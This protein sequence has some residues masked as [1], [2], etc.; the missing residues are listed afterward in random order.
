MDCCWYGTISTFLKTDKASW[1]YQMK[2]AHLEM[3]MEKPSDL[4]VDAWL[5]C[6]DVLQC[7]LSKINPQ[8]K[9]YHIIFEYLLPR[10]GGRRPDVILILGNHIVVLEFKQKTNYNEA[11]LDQAI[12]YARDIQ[13]YHLESRKYTVRPFLVATK[14]K[15]SGREHGPIRGLCPDEIP[16]LLNVLPIQPRNTDIGKWLKS[17][18]VPLPS[19]VEAAIDI[20]DNKELPHVKRASSAGIPDALIYLNDITKMARK[21]GERHI[22]FV[23]GVP[24][25]GKTLLGLQ[26]VY[27]SN[28]EDIPAVFLSGNGPLVQVLS[29][30]LESSILIK[31]IRKFI[32]TYIHSQNSP[33]ESIIV[34][35]EAQRA[36]DEHYK[37]NKHKISEPE[38]MIKITDKYSNGV[39]LLALI[40]EG[41]EIYLGEEGGINKWVQAIIKSTSSYRIH[42]PTKLLSSFNSLHPETS[43]LLDLDQSLRSHTAEATTAWIN[44]ILLGNFSEAKSLSKQIQNDG[45]GIYITDDLK[46]AKMYCKQKYQDSPQ[47]T[48]GLLASSRAKNLQPHGIRNDFESTAKVDYGKWY[49]DSAMS[50]ALC[51]DMQSVVTEFGCQ[52]LELDL[53]IICWGDDLLW[54]NDHWQSNGHPKANDPHKLLLNSYRVLLSRGRDGIIIFIPHEKK[55]LATYRCI[56]DSGAR[57]L[58]MPSSGT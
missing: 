49:N 37:K 17:E 23:T 41:Q 38:I 8:Y 14:R 50:I 48:Y 35:D 1:L 34:F 44:A 19:L 58:V 15:A 42:C 9:D 52:G 4:Q 24:G 11:D 31:G 56:V 47:K 16:A 26:M 10:E 6:F 12:G 54:V 53:P 46:K 33:R 30:A 51:R 36:W 57:K 20:F 40:G 29:N 39:V 45:F 27:Q 13:S 28:K 2:A 22:I 3:L 55:M 43:E 18:Y 21:N 32:D 25:A 7:Q 5:D